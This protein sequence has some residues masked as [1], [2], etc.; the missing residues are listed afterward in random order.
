MK[1]F[2]PWFFAGVILLVGMFQAAFVLQTA[3]TPANYIEQILFVLVVALIAFI[4]ALIIDR[5]SGNRIGWLMLAVAFVTALPILYDPI[6]LE[7]FLPNPPSTLTF[8]IWLILWFHGWFWLLQMIAIFQ[9]VF[10]F[11]SG[12]I[13]SPRWSW[14]NKVMLGTIVLSAFSAMASDQIGPINNAWKLN[15]PMGFLPRTAIDGISFVWVIGLLSLSIG[16]LISIVIRFRLANDTI[17]QQIKWLLFAGALLAVIAIFGLGYF[18]TYDTAPIWLNIIIN[19]GFMTLPLAIANAILRYRLYD[20]DI[21]IRKTLQYAL[22]TGLL[23]LVYFG[24]VV[25]LQSLTENFF[26]EQTP[27]VIVLS[28]LAI[29]A[30]FNPLR[31]RVQDFIDRRFYRK[32]Y[33]AQRALAQFT[34]TARDEVEI[35]VLQAELLR[36]VKETLQPETTVL[37]LKKIERSTSDER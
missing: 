18:S 24:S 1:R 15:N 14:I 16:S 32:K 20:I 23:G 9:I 22:L 31:I 5:T 12:N 11:P 26:G 37:W 10:L 21:I 8:G 6:V 36:V 7:V 27:L 2:L 28:T 29:A 4:G 34:Q 3:V 25:L 35:D 13:L 19:L 17:R 33:D 30:L